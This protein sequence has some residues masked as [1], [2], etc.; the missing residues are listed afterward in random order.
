MARLIAM[1][2]MT[3]PD[4]PQPITALA[5]GLLLLALGLRV[6]QLGGPQFTG[7]EGF[8]FELASRPYPDLAREILRLGEPQPIGSFI[9][10]K[11]WL[12]L[13]GATEFNL[14]MLNVSFG[15]VAVALGWSLGRRLTRTR[16]AAF[17]AA[18]LLATNPFGLEHSRE[19]RTYAIALCMSLACLAAL[20]TFARR[21]SGPAVVAV[22]GCEWAA[23]QAHYVSAFVVAA[24]S[25]AVLAWWLLARRGGRAWSRPPHLPRWLLAQAIVATLTLPWLLLARGVAASYP[26]TGKG[27]L[28]LPAVVGEEMALFTG[29][30]VLTSWTAALISIGIMAM[31]LG[32]LTLWLGPQP[33]KIAALAL[34]LGFF[35]PLLAVWVATWIRPVFH[36]RY[37][38]VIWPFFALLA[39]AAATLRPRGPR[40]L[41][42]V[43]SG[44]LC[45]ASV[46]GG[47]QYLAGL[48][49]INTWR[50]LVAAFQDRVRDLP[51][52][53]V[54]VTVPWPDPAFGYYY[55]QV[56]NVT[57][58]PAAPKTP[59]SVR[60][61]MRS[62]ADRRIRRVLVHS[63]PGGWWDTANLA[64][65]L[66]PAPYN[67]I[68][69]VYAQERRIDVFE[70]V[71]AD[72]LSELDETFVN[73]VRVRGVEF[74]TDT[75]H[76][77]LGLE[78]A[79][80]GTPR[81]TGSEKSFL[82][83][84]D[85]SAPNVIVAQVDL[86]LIEQDLRVPALLRGIPLPD[87][88][89]RGTYEIWFGLYDPAAPG[90]P[91]IRTTDGNDRVLLG[92][93]D[94]GR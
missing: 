91:R 85:P 71:F 5:L 28:S 82:H 94:L 2:S 18:L 42:L 33:G 37:L 58:L 66:Q 44:V 45:F 62:F 7:D 90:A 89:R 50:P 87:T 48:D 19:Y 63:A 11:A 3:S 64:S 78:L 15:V 46:A 88:L 54:L 6:F 21:P 41:G 74:L 92:R 34:G 36:A 51:E 73:G 12:D 76:S 1:V 24:L 67:R 31:A 30:D 22:V 68:D 20:A 23:I 86:P 52:T 53:S 4:R 17:V 83:I 72:R 93:V 59:E 60:A 56:R 77:A 40:V 26:G 79:L 13:G 61:Q 81:L 55:G 57:L 10:E 80:S 65:T 35:L 25:A 27:L 70:Y 38:I 84:V 16:R 32:W 29:G 8:T 14:R 47:A 49:L 43:A 9:L 39:G 75:Q 69:S